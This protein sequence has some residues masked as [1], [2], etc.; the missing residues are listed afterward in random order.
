MDTFWIGLQSDLNTLLLIELGPK[1]RGGTFWAS[2][3]FLL[4]SGPFSC[5]LEES[6]VVVGVLCRVHD[7][8][9]AS[10]R[11]VR[12]SVLIGW[13]CSDALRIL[14]QQP[15]QQ[16][17]ELRARPENHYNERV[18]YCHSTEN[19]LIWRRVSPPPPHPHPIMSVRAETAA[20]FSSWLH[21]RLDSAQK[22]SSPRT[23]SHLS[24]S[25]VSHSHARQRPGEHPELPGKVH[26]NVR[27]CACH[28]QPVRAATTIQFVFNC[29]ICGCDCIISA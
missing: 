24:A 27:G 23:K 15:G 28:F 13:V 1:Q 2:V 7:S 20:V 18:R 8:S 29:I 10:L 26:L 4:F 12:L 14:L 9:T 6:D 21:P 25:K 11:V 5:M 16:G 22:L 17:G 3:T 19:L